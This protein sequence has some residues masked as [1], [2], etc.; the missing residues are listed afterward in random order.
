V[1]AEGP[2]RSAR[3]GDGLK[4]YV[5]HGRFGHYVQLGE[6]PP[7][8][9]GKSPRCRSARR[10]PE[11]Q[12]V[13]DH[14]RPGAQ[15]LSL[16][17]DLGAHPSDGEIIVASNGRFGPYVKH[18]DQFRSLEEG[19]DVHAITLERALELLAAPKKS[20][21]RTVTR[22]V[23]RTFG[24]HPQGGAEVKLME[25][26]YGPYVTDGS[27]NASVPP[28][29][30]PGALTLE[31]VVE[32]LKAGPAGPSAAARPDEN[33][34]HRGGASSGTAIRRVPAHGRRQTHLQGSVGGMGQNDV[35]SARSKRFVL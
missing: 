4:V 18:G 33:E 22:A 24:A 21:R 11:H 27:V 8:V 15:L 13:G 35:I 10:F 29:A 23:L 25:G 1:K 16:P 34:P 28:A 12:R 14:A 17:R 26:R 2:R 19:D 20:R 3:T 5:Q 6:T 7:R 31:A 32:L 9:K 30:D